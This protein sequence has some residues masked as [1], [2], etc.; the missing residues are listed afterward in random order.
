MQRKCALALSPLVGVLIFAACISNEAPRILDTSVL[1]DTYDTNGPYR[2]STVVLDDRK[3]KEVLL[4]Y[5]TY[6]QLEYI[7][8]PMKEVNSNLFIGEIPGQPGGTTVTYFIGAKDSKNKESFDP[9]YAPI[10]TYGFTVLQSEKP[11]L[12]VI[13]GDDVGQ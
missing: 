4:Y 11:T 3:V 10:D 8:A 5:R 12:D 13:S 2:I 9:I 6:G 7:V 1:S